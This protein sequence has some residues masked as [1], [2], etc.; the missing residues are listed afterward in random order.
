ME[1]TR[2]E[3]ECD[4]YRQALGEHYIALSTP[5]PSQ[6]DKYGFDH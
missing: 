6:D 4:R 1:K 5:K 3:N 2:H